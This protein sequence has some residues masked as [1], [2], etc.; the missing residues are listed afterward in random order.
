MNGMDRQ[1]GKSLGGKDHL[2]QSIGDI[3]GTPLGTR[4]GRREYG[5]LIPQLL[6]QPNNELGRLRIYAATA[7]ALL[8][9]EGRARITRVAV[10][11][12]AEPQQVIVTIIGRRSDAQ[13]RPAFAISSPISALSALARKAR[14]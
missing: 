2:E 12:G 7:L 4:L 14:T 10:S 9:Q 11:A 8:R 6:D 3:L 13:G 1:T 5:S